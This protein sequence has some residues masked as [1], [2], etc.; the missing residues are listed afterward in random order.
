MEV[1]ADHF[2]HTAYRG[3]GSGVSSLTRLEPLSRSE[4]WSC[5]PWAVGVCSQSVRLGARLHQTWT[6]RDTSFECRRPSSPFPRHGR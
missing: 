4:E 1:L 6:I 2:N 3:G 5:V